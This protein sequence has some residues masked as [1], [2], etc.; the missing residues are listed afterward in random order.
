MRSANQVTKVNR[1]TRRFY[2][3]AFIIS[4][5]VL[6]ALVGLVNCLQGTTF[7]GGLKCSFGYT[8]SDLIVKVIATVIFLL[9]LALLLGPVV[10]TIIQPLRAKRRKPR[11]SEE[12]K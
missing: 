10:A 3:I 12:A 9:F 11:R 5:I 7:V 4:A 8:S 6:V 2:E 1:M